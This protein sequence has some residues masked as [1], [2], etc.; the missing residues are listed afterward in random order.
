M[1]QSALEDAPGGFVIDGKLLQPPYVFDV[2]G[3]PH[4]L[5]GALTF[6]K[7]PIEAFQTDGATVDVTELKSLDIESVRQPDQPEY[8]QPAPAQ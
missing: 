6:P 4:T 7:G 3:E 2:I 8:A 1:A 5:S